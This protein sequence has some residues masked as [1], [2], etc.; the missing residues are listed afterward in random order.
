MRAEV[1]EARTFECMEQGAGMQ[2]GSLYSQ[3]CLGNQTTTFSGDVFISRSAP[4]G[5]PPLCLVCH[6]REG[7]TIMGLLISKPNWEIA[8]SSSERY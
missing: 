5:Q 4:K 7:H 8:A 6:C 2:G 1:R 3:P